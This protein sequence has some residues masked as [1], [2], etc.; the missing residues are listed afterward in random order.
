MI[1]DHLIVTASNTETWHDCFETR[2]S[3]YDELRISAGTNTL[4]PPPS[5]ESTAPNLRTSINPISFT[6]TG[7]AVTVNLSGASGQLNVEW[8]NP[9]DGTTTSGGTTTGGASHSFTAPFNGDAVLYIYKPFVIKSRV[10]IPFV[11]K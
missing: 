10:Y 7:G 4:V 2:R 11:K 3:R 5:H 6:A 1:N 8:F 9:E